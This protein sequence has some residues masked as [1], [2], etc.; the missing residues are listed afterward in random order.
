[1]ISIL[2]RSPFIFSKENIKDRVKKILK[3]QRG[4]SAVL[5]GLTSGLKKINEPFQ[6]NPSIREISETVGVLSGIGAL[7]LAIKLKK[8]GLIK[9]LTAGPN[10][11]VMPHEYNKIICD[12]NIDKVL[13][14]SEWVKNLYLDQAPEISSKV[15]VW[16]AGT[17]MDSI[18]FDSNRTECIIYKKN[19]PEE[20]YTSIIKDLD[21]RNLKYNLLEYGKFKK[22]DYFRLLEKSKFMIYLQNTESQGLALQEA[23]ARN[24]PTLVWNIGHVLYLDKFHIKDKIS[25]PYLNE[26]SGMFFQNEK[27]FSSKIDIFIKNLDKFDPQKYCAETLSDIISAKMYANIVNEIKR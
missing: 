17:N 11:I 3:I 8:R 4:P 23:W 10:I 2:T 7:K 21:N 13:V 25:A 20:I 14:P 15:F 22:E 19:V 9:H 12:P 6:I 27:D 5:D 26:R 24:V 18:F 1:M 16:P